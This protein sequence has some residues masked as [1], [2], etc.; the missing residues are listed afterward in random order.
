MRNVSF[1]GARQLGLC[2]AGKAR[3]TSTE[4][5][6]DVSDGSSGAEGEASLERD[7]DD[8]EGHVNP[9]KENVRVIGESQSGKCFSL[10]RCRCQAHVK[11]LLLRASGAVL[12]L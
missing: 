11:C 3:A 9:R 8:C 6:G 1:V 2:V 10:L 12:V 4:T 7:K 5:H